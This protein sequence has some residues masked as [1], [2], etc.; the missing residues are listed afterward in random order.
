VQNSVKFSSGLALG[1]GA[2]E[3]LPCDSFPGAILCIDCHM[4]DFGPNCNAWSS[5][6]AQ[7]ESFIAEA[8][9]RGNGSA[10]KENVAEKS[11]DELIYRRPVELLQNLIRFNTTNPPGNEAGCIGYVKNLLTKAGYETVLLAREASRPNLICRLKG[12]GDAPPLLLYGHVDVVTT[13]N[14]KWTHPPFEGKMEDG[15]IWGRGALDMKGGIAMMLSA[16]LRAR[17]EGLQPAGDVVVAFLSDEEN[18]GDYGAKF[19][20]ENYPNLFGGIHYAIGEFGGFSIYMGKRKFYP[21]MVAEKQVCWMKAIVHGPG[22][23]GSQPVSGG[24]M[25]KLSELLRSLD[26]HPLPVHVTPVARHM[27][28]S[29]A[30]TLPFP[31]RFILEQLLNPYLSDSV[32]KLLGERGDILAPLLHNTVSATVVRG[33]EKIN[34]IPSE[35]T[36]ELDGRVLPGF[37]PENLMAELRQVIGG[38]AEL[39]VI[40][41]DAGPAEPQMGLFPVLADILRDA[42]PSGNPIP[43]LLTGTSDARFF[44]RLG[45]QTYGFLPMKLP[46]DFDFNRTIHAADERIPAE[47]VAFGGEAIYELLRRYQG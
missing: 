28:E 2:L 6:I 12:R 21:I 9:L 32:L 3:L 17:I 18:L 1:I 8:R 25:T 37:G 39:Q 16:V 5:D 45:I 20:V 14:Q 24:A 31:T 36:L 42:D 29:M 44:S 22:G 38:G 13:S 46:S 7:G 40:R 27:I 41:H 4:P 10:M 43:L 35:I 34:V 11:G 33:G 23:H 26:E 15:Y 47:A 19:L 30:S